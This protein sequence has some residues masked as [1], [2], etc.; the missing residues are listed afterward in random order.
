MAAEGRLALLEQQLQNLS[1]GGRF[2]D[3]SLAS[4][5]RE[6][7]GN[8]KGKS[9]NEF[10]TQVEQ[11]ARVSNWT[12]EDQV[13][14]IKAKLCGEA[15]QFLNAREDLTSGQVTYETF[16]EALVARFSEKLPARYYYNLLHEARQERGESPLQ[17]LDRCALSSKTIRKI[18]NS[19]EQR[20]LKEEAEFRLL[21]SFIHGSRGDVGK[22]LKYRSPSTIDEALNIATIVYNAGKL[23]K[24]EKDKEIFWPKVEPKKCYRCHRTDHLISQCKARPPQQRFSRDNCR[25]DRFAETRR[26]GTVSKAP[27]TCKCKQEGHI[28]KF[29]NQGPQRGVERGKRSPN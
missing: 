15:L 8:E 11:C 16:K 9:V 13:N 10:L 6:W 27:V 28:S 14:I 4:S 19:V 17:F 22:E 24:Q 1:L 2:K 3:L 25:N 7:S 18:Q 20:I 21:T 29:C 23:D 5:I 12:S 26:E